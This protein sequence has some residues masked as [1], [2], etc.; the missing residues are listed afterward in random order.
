ME[1]EYFHVRFALT[2]YA[3]MINLNT[4]HH[5]KSLKLKA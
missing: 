3:K 4:K 2:T 1:E 5:V